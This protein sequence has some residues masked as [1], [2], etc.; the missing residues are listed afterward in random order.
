MIT[1]NRTLA[2]ERGYFAILEWLEERE[3]VHEEFLAEGGTPSDRN[4]FTIDAYTAHLKMI[5]ALL[6]VLKKVS[7]FYTWVPYNTRDVGGAYLEDSVDELIEEI[8]SG[9]STALEVG[10]G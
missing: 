2:D 3:R 7:E 10:R 1:I 4:S 8:L 6:V 9:I 5:D